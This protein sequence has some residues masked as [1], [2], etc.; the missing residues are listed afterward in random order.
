[1][2]GLAKTRRMK[3]FLLVWALVAP[4]VATAEPA[5][6]NVQA[7][8]LAGYPVPGSSLEPLT[9]EDSWQ[10]HAKAFDK[11]WQE[12]DRR[13]MATIAEWM[14][15]HA[16]YAY[17]DAS[18][19]FYLFS[20]PDF[21]YANAFYPNASTTIMC[22]IEPVGN[23]PDVASLSPGER[24]EA[25]HNLRNSLD[26]ILSFSFFRTAAMKTDFK[27][28]ALNGTLP[29][30][31]LFISHGGCQIT[32]VDKV[33]LDETGELYLEAN[34]TPGVRIQFTGPNGKARTVYYFS[35]DL[36]NYGIKSNP[37]FMAFCAKQGT[38]NALVKA[39]SYLMHMPE[40]SHARDFLLTRTRSIIQDDSGI[41]FG[42][43]GKAGWSV[44]L[45]GNYDKPI[46]LFKERYQSDLHEA[47]KAQPTAELPFSVGYR[48]RLKESSLMLARAPGV[49]PVPQEQAVIKAEPVEEVPPRP[50]LIAEPVLE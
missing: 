21:L 4:A 6:P 12:L 15:R 30:L 42:S 17:E 28:T 26:A 10:Q 13:Q 11:A 48:W 5:P 29:V 33:W 38:G 7:R 44:T 41:P 19:L 24:A 50:I 35:S 9:Q 31:Y 40:F 49:N 47:F 3:S 27:N 45:A 23:L 39:A 36:S 37:G 34:K 8:F 20:G 22:G 32:A 2:T 46:D 18:P 1:M 43:L 16:P 14:P 25:L